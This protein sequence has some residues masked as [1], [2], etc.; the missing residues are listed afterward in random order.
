MRC[1][2][3]LQYGK[4]RCDGLWNFT[5]CGVHKHEPL[6]STERSTRYNMLLKTLREMGRQYDDVEGGVTL[7]VP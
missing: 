5:K 2:V 3:T 1:S 7:T 6:D 4:M